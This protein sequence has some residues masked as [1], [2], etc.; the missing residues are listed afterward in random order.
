M[1]PAPRRRSQIGKSGAGRCL[2]SS[3]TTRHGHGIMHTCRTAM[4]HSALL[5][6]LSYNCALPCPEESRIAAS[7]ESATPEGQVRAWI[8]AGERY[9]VEF[10]RG[11]SRSAE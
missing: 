11:A 5:Y 6:S 7:G 9:D 2:G 10:K 4:R 8:A 1:F 3:G